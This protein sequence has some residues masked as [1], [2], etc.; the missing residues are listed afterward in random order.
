MTEELLRTNFDRNNG[1]EMCFERTAYD[2]ITCHPSIMT[3]EKTNLT[4]E[5]AKYVVICEKAKGRETKEDTDLVLD[6][7]NQNAPKK[8]RYITYPD[9]RRS[10]PSRWNTLIQ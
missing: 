5:R 4:S 3:L 1:E 9:I 8:I 6:F 2:I 10:S 7:L